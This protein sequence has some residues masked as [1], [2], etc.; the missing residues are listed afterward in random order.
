MIV[1]PL[2][3]AGEV[4]GTLNMARMGGDESHFS[5]DEFELVQLFAGQASIA[6]RNA[7]AHGA[8]VTQAEHDALTGLRNH[9]AFQRELGELHRARRCR[10]ALLMLDLDAFKAYNDTH[11][12]PAGD[13]LLAR[14]A[15]AMT[16][17]GPRRRP[18]LPLRRR[19]VRDPRCRASDE[20]G[21]REVAERVRAAVAGLTGD[22]RAAGHRQRG[23]RRTTPRTRGTRTPSSTRADRALYLAKPPNRDPPAERRPD[24][25][26][27]PRGRGPDD[28]Q[29]AGAPRA[30]RAAA[31]R[32]WSARPASSASSTGSSTC[33]R[34]RRPRTATLDLVARVGMGVFEGY[35]GYRLPRAPGVG[36]AVVRTRPPGRRGRLRRVPGAARRTCRARQFG[37]ICAVPLTSGDEVLG[38]I[39]LAS[40]DASRPF[41]EREVEALARF[42]QLAS[43]ALDNARLFER[44]QTEVRRRAHA[45]LHD[46]LTGLPNRTLLLNRLA[47]QLEAAHGPGAA[48]DARP[49]ARVALILLDLDR[50]KVVN[51]SL[52]HAAGD[53]LL[54]QVGAAPGGGGPL[55]R[56]RRPPR[57]A[58]SS[59]SCWGRS[60]A[61][62]RRSGWPRGSRRP[63]R[64]PVRPRR[65]GRSASGPAWGSRSGRG[66]PRH[67]V[68]P[69]QAGGDRAPP[70]QGGPDPHDGP[71]RPRDA[72]PDPRPGD[73]G[74]RP[75]A[76]DRALASCGCT[77]SR[78]WTSPPGA[79]LGM[80]ALLRWQHP[81]RGHRAAARRSSRWRRRP[82]LILPIGR[83]VLE[84]ACRQLRDWQRRFPAAASPGGERQPVG[85]PVRRVRTSSPTSRRSWTTRAWIPACLELEITE[86]VVMDQSEASVERLHGPPGAG[87]QAGPRRLRDGLLVAVLPAPAA[88]ST[89]SRSTARSCPGWGRTRRTS[90]SSRRSSRSPTAWASTWWRRASRPRRSS[91]SLRELA[92]DRGQG[93][94]FARP[95]A[96]PRAIEDAARRRAVPTRRRP[97]RRRQEAPRP[98][99]RPSS[100]CRRRCGARTGT[101]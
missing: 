41:S 29:A 98:G 90:R 88:R 95:L 80:E 31:R 85:A 62:G 45:A 20:P 35:E 5:R 12:H 55:H 69:A 73:A 28:A 77:T 75:A 84:T 3:V 91:S 4:I 63:S 18:R 96:G 34:G 79:V 11:G 9:G 72:R 70:G 60:A 44:A 48:G 56:H 64:E 30:T 14:I 66:A 54:A 13:A 86:S 67:P 100:G 32:S 89:R 23:H 8:V 82:G 78:W 83:W 101:C 39:G 1:C 46:P 19:R 52:G 21:A 76:G 50:F 40:G 57:L 42:G 6:L 37:A 43:I 27:L 24:A 61:C 49:G 15:G 16:R 68:R 53:L 74:A 22:V 65:R 10:F 51:E 94:W 7:E 2:L 97:R 87:R 59:G 47:E 36:W 99:G 17:G 38:L 25:G 71:V 81:T 58:T 93:Y 26:P 33:S 92:C